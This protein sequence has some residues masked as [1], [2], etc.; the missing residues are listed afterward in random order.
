MSD[1]KIEVSKVFELSD[2]L[3]WRRALWEAHW[4]SHETEFTVEELG[5]TGYEAHEAWCEYYWWDDLLEDL[6]DLKTLIESKIK[7]ASRRVDKVERANEQ[8]KK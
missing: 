4:A 3:K 2:W 1:V 5:E 6:D 8:A 7:A